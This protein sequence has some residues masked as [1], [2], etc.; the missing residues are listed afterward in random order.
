MLT[1]PEVSDHAPFQQKYIDL[2]PDP[3]METLKKQQ[4]NFNEYI[5]SL[6]KDQL[7]IRYA[8]DKWTIREVIM[9]IV[10]T[11]KIFAYR[12]LAASR[13]DTQDLPGFD[14]DTYITNYD[15]SHLDVSYLSQYYL[16]TRAATLILFEGMQDKD[17]KKIGH[18]SG[19]K[20]R[21]NAMPYMIAGHIMHH[22]QI[23]DERYKLS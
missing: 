21:L 19:Y 11:E 13:E 3:V 20:M 8:P 22:K 4:G 10:D 14:Q 18:M 6:S 2:V 9:H 23:L 7:D 1:R 5:V 12:T 16:T 15:S 17:W